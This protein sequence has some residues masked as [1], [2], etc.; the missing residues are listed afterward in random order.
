MPVFRTYPRAYLLLVA[1]LLLAACGA[2]PE[3]F[4]TPTP[5]AAPTPKPTSGRAVGRTLR[6]MYWQAPEH[7]NPHLSLNSKETDPS[8]ITYEPLASFDKDGKLVSFL[9]A[10]IP[11]LENGDVA[12]DG[13]SVTWKLKRGV[14]WSDGHPFTAA[15]VR[16]TYLYATNPDVGAVSAGAYADV[17]DVQ[18]PDDYSVK[19]VFKDVNPSWSEPFVGTQGMILPKHVFEP[20]NNRNARGAP[21]NL[22]P[23]GTGPYRVA[24]FKTEEVLFLGTDLVQTIKVVFEPNP[25][26]REPDKP[27]FS[28]IEFKGGG[29]ASE[30]TRSVLQTGDI[31]FAWNTSVD[32]DTL[33]RLQALGKGH[34][35]ANLVPYVERIQLNRTDPNKAT[36]DGEVSSLA[37]PHPFFSDLRVRQAFAAAID[38]DAITKLYPGSQPAT[39][40]LVSPPIFASKNA[41]YEFNPSR[42]RALLDQAGW[43]DHDGDGW[44]DKDG[45]TLRV[46]FQTTANSAVRQR[47]QEVVR[48]NL[49][50]IGADVSLNIID[51]N[52]FFSDDSANMSSFRHFRADMQEFS[53]GNLSPDPGAFMKYWLCSSIPQK[54]NSWS[55]ENA[56]RWCNQQY[57]AL[58]AQSQHEIDPA[59]RAQLFIQMNDM[60]IDDIVMIPLVHTADLYG[61]NN[62]LIGVDL[63]PWDASV[64]N[65]KD[66][67][68]A[69]P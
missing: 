12:R 41:R 51:S 50:A 22:R 45:M 13:L 27:Y 48:D 9:A 29:T 57:D 6:I 55:G 21:A 28:R 37:F 10:E 59:K 15:D 58:F 44:R 3:A 60:L 67:R 11:S 42:A 5:V 69:A 53:D 35:L 43:I 31:D 2:P 17:A 16:F 63:T 23:V 14:K 46:A 8:R 20:Y 4:S 7:L 56:E 65:I 62:A 34:M 64:W 68:L 40:N 26:F 18:T 30:A 19:V 33:E 24:N 38:R 66:W 61:A 49:K 32:A 39:N 52:A 36:A 25:Y 47:T 1:V 54:S